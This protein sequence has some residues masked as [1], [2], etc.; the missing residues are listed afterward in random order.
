MEGPP[1]GPGGEDIPWPD[2]VAP[3]GRKASSTR[4]IKPRT[5][6]TIPFLSFDTNHNQKLNQG[7]GP[8]WAYPPYLPLESEASEG[9]D[10]KQAKQAFMHACVYS[11]Q[12]ISSL[13]MVESS[14]LSLYSMFALHQR[15]SAETRDKECACCIRS[16]KKL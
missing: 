13:I 2:R 4:K 5:S 15:E 9:A 7:G 16:N 12:S 11:N 8:S 14:N 10:E 3:W 6:N 1:L